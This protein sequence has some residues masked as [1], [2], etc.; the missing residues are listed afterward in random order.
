MP[1]WL[2]TISGLG[3]TTWN[4]IK[5]IGPFLISQS[6]TASQAFQRHLGRVAE[7]DALR[8]LLKGE[9]ETRSAIRRSLLERYVAATDEERVRIERDIEYIDGVTRQLNIAAKS[10]SYGPREEPQQQTAPPPKPIEDH[11]IDRFNELAFKRNEDWR[12]ELWL[13]R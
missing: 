6:D 2:D 9:V 1:N 5:S 3:Q 4:T 13:V 12:N 8:A 7:V 11:W 10:L